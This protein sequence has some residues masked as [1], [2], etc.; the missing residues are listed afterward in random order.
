MIND[1]YYTWLPH[2]Q[3]CVCYSQLGKHALAYAHNEIARQYLPDHPSILHNKRYLEPLLQQS[4]LANKAEEWLRIAEQVDQKFKPTEGTK[5]LNITYVM[6]HMKI[7]GG[8]KIVLEYTNYLIKRGHMVNIVCYDPEPS[9]IK[10]KANYIQVPSGRR[11]VDSIPD[12]DVIVTTVWD[13]MV[14]CYM[15]QRAP[16]I[17]FEHGDIYIFEFDNYDKNTQDV[18][19]Q[20]WSVP[21]P[22][23]AVSSG[24]AAQLEKNFNRKPQVLHNALNDKIFY[25][26]TKHQE[27]ERPRILFVGPE[28]WSYKGI[29]DILAAIELVRKRGYEIDPIWVTQKT[30]DSAFEGTVHIGPPQEKLGELYRNCDIYVCGS[31]FESFPLPPLEAMTSGCAVISTRNV[32][33]LEYAEHDQNCLLTNIGDPNGLADAIIE[34]IDNAE[35]RAFLVKNGYETAAKFKW[36]NIMER[37]E[38]FIYDQVQTWNEKA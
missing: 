31:Y 3:L 15:V 8:V 9:W 17:H 29:P 4:Q 1:V 37:L 27:S 23:L 19:K 21:V 11:L 25:P 2:L 34:L 18:W 28:Q 12:T 22:I 7:C 16:V 32:G 26:R 30:P 6:N 24:L 14:D 10:V 20:R 35:K 38:M 33:V 13:Q 36:E 5:R